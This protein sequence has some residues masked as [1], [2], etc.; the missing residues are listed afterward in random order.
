MPKTPEEIK[1][2][3]KLWHQAHKEEQKEKLRTLKAANPEKYL[4]QRQKAERKRR[5]KINSLRAKNYYAKNKPRILETIRNKS[6]ALRN[7]FIEAYGGKCICCGEFEHHFLTLDHVSGNGAGRNHRKEIGKNPSSNALLRD[8]KSKGWPKD[9][10]QLLCFNC[11]CGR[12]KNGGI[13]PHKKA[14]YI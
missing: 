9:D 7:E 14:T 4:K 8:L 10:Y 11:N 3:N 12:A 2:Y 13:C 6:I 5:G 1:I